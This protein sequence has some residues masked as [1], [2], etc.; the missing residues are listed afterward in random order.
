M[1]EWLLQV[2][3]NSPLEVATGCRLK[4]LAHFISSLSF[5]F[6]STQSTHLKY[7]LR[8]CVQYLPIFKMLQPRIYRPVTG[9]EASLA[10]LASSL[11]SLALCTKHSHLQPRASIIFVR[12]ASHAQQGRAN[13]PSDSAGRRLGAKKGS[14]EWV[15][16]GNIIFK[17]RGTAQGQDEKKLF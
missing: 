9:S 4:W 5:R 14:S 10:A 11:N 2:P 1:P 13:G 7:M 15:H 3:E 17:Q 16:P 8:S 6:I 12:H